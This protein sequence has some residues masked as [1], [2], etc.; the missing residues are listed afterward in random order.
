MNI[1]G[2][3]V[4][5]FVGWLVAGWVARKIRR[6]V[7]RRNLDATLGAFFAN[8]ARYL[9]LIAVLLGVLGVFGIETSTFAA[10]IGAA[11][12]AV[13]LAFQGTLSNFASGVMLL[14][15]RPFKVGE[16]VEAGGEKGTVMEIELFHTELKTP[17]AKRV[18]V[19]NGKIWSDSI[20]N[21][22]HFTERRVDVD[23][24]VDYSA[25]IDEVRV[26]LQ[27]V[28]EAIPDGLN[29][30]PPAAF[31]KGLGGS[32]VDWQVRV[33]ANTDDY[34]KVHEQIVRD[35]KKALDEAGIGIPFPQMDVHF[36]AEAV[37]AVRG[38]RTA[39]AAR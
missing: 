31:L 19:P 30:P 4:A 29:E 20:T 33:W 8:V 38:A 18:I 12:L 6:V 26:V 24:G 2:A 22:G 23:V 5:I 13:G 1:V 16:F 35:V 28:A 36:D 32:S 21:F 39:P 34:W 3:L 25:D 37:D 14:V 7:E 17:D 9:I 11:G 10:V 27:R 15:F